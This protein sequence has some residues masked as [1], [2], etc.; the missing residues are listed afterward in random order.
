LQTQKHNAF[1][2]IELLVVIAIIGIFSAFALPNVASWLTKREV[3]K[4]VY[5]VITYIQERKSEVTNGKY[6]MIQLL[7]KPSLEV[8]TMS[9]GNFSNT[10]HSINS[11]S[12]YKKNSECDYGTTQS[13]FIRNTD[14]ETLKLSNSNKDSKVHVYP[15]DSHNP[16]AS[17][18]CI[19]KDGSISFMRKRKTERDSSTGKKVDIFIFCSKSNSDKKTCNPKAKF[20]HMYKITLDRYQNIKVY[21]KNTK[22]N[23]WNKIDG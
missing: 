5:D 9:P 3:K 4:E 18:I 11:N 10:Y 1:S 23:N 2:L 14:L 22:K 16:V 20:E 19:T 13:D 21:I 15:N 8:Y 12:P 6:G 17:T 7:L